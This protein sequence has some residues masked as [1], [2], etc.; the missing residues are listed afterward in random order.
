M[1]ALTTT[2][3]EGDD[4]TVYDVSAASPLWLAAV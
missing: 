1:L 3:R 2:P 4:M